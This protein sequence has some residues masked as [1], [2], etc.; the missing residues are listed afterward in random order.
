MVFVIA[1]AAQV[2]A[3]LVLELGDIGFD[4]PGRFGLDYGH[5][6]LL[7]AAWLVASCVG[8]GM[9]FRMRRP[10]ALVL[11]LVAICVPVVWV[12]TR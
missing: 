5:L 8:L 2:L 4:R 11:Q 9:A 10:G 7:T 6:L 12:M 3:L 1:L